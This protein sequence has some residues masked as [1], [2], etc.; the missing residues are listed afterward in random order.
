MTARPA[1]GSPATSSQA[2]SEPPG[3]DR[4]GSDH[5]EADLEPG[6]THSA[7]R[8]LLADP[9]AAVG[10]TLVAVFVVSALA[11]PWVATHDPLA[12]DLAHTLEGPSRS[13]WFGTDGLGRDVYSRIVWGARPSLGMTSLAAMVIM[14]IGVAVGI[15]SGLGGRWIDGLLMRVVDALLAFPPLVLSLAIVG[16]LG[17][18]LFSIMVALTAVGWAGYA[19][20][21]R[22]LVV[23]LREREFVEAAVATGTSTTMIGIRHLLPCVIPPVVIFLTLNLSGLILTVSALS[24][25]GLGIAPPAAEWGAMLSDGRRYFFSSGHLML[26]PGLAIFVAVLGINLVGDRLRDILDRRGRERQA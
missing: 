18:G 8:D 26:F 22:G 19:R 12:I 9:A 10:V 7:L 3:E 1:T 25:L 11:A 14:V 5:Q 13:H 24:F 21:V 20:L 17:P 4:V 6:S 16:A 15:A 23:E 2:G